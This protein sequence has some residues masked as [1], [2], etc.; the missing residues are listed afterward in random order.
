MVQFT[1]FLGRVSVSA[2]HATR[3]ASQHQRVCKVVVSRWVCVVPFE[4]EWRTND[5]AQLNAIGCA[6]DG[7]ESQGAV[8]A[9]ARIVEITITIKVHRHGSQEA[10]EVPRV[11]AQQ[12]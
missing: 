4:S 6:R 5:R 8:I 12:S 3:I 1:S 7:V 10:E 2:K 11:G 9:A